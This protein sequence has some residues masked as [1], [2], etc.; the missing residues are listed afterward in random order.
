[1]GS[2]GPS[3]S[4]AEP[5]EFYNDDE[6]TDIADW[7]L[8]AQQPLTRRRQLHVASSQ[9]PADDAADAGG[10]RF[11]SES[12]RWNEQKME[13]DQLSSSSSLHNADDTLVTDNAA[14][15]S[16]RNYN[17]D[18]MIIIIHSQF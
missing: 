6:L 13:M 1:M 5:K 18:I 17:Y 4:S 7:T 3:S 14:S 9:A 2:S 10:L 12:C 16:A 15:A 8:H 11:V